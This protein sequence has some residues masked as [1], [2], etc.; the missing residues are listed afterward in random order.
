M[1]F[2][3]QRFSQYVNLT[4]AFSPQGRTNAAESSYLSVTIGPSG[5]WTPDIGDFEK[6]GKSERGLLQSAL[7]SRISCFI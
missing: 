7:G 5:H 1:Y 2:H 4:S 6:V 3:V